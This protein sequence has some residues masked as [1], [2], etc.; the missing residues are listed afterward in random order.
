MDLQ[1][2]G[3]RYRDLDREAFLE[4]FP[5]PFL[6]RAGSTLKDESRQV[7]PLDRESLPVGRA[8]AARVSIP[9]PSVSKEHA[10]LRREDEAWLVTDE[11]STNGT[12]LDGQRL[13][14]GEPY[15]IE[16]GALVRFGVAAF[17]ITNPAELHRLL[18]SLGP[19]WGSDSEEGPN[20]SEDDETE[21]FFRDAETA[22]LVTRSD[23]SQT[24]L[25]QVLW[26]VE[27]RQSTGRVTVLGKDGDQGQIWFRAGRPCQAS[28]SEDELQG[29]P[30][31]Q[32]LVQVHQGS[33][34]LEMLESVPERR[35]EGTF[36]QLLFGQAWAQW[37][38]EQEAAEARLHAIVDNVFDA[39]VTVNGKG[40]IETVNPAAVALFGKPAA[41]LVGAMIETLL[42]RQDA[43]ERIRAGVGAVQ[44]LEGSR[45]G[46]PF[47]LELA[48]GFRRLADRDLFILTFRDLTQRKREEATLQV[49][50]KLE[51]VGRL[52]G[53]MTH[54]FNNLLTVIAGYAELLLEERVAPRTCGESILKA[55]KRATDLT[56]KILATTRLEPSAPVPLNLN[57]VL[58]ELDVLLRSILGE[59]CELELELSPELPNV[60]FDRGQLEQIVMNLAFNAR[61]ASVGPCQLLIRTELADPETVR[62]L[63]RDSGQ[64]IDAETLERVRE[65]FFTTKRAGSGLGLSVVEG[66]VR[67]AGGRLE[68]RSELGVGTEVELL[69]PLTPLEATAPL[70]ED[71]RRPGRV[72]VVEDEGELREL[73]RVILEGQGHQVTLARDGVE[74]LERFDGED[75]V[76][77][78]VVMP[79]LGGIGLVK[80]LLQLRPTQRVLYLSGYKDQALVGGF[81]LLP[82]PF[83]KTELQDAV[84]EAIAKS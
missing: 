29:V 39:I 8:F 65:P 74:A 41:D 2:F 27:A 51:A 19:A 35:I 50:Q 69:V 18:S 20:L 79:R 7:Y 59:D 44:E 33:L 47:P 76:V 58:G 4:R 57:Q 25:I 54:N 17:T 71:A 15:W 13:E 23:L 55:T 80:E 70:A 75:L 1:T 81:P 68:I 67:Q 30:A 45:D 38:R 42:D 83:S 31:L 61:D 60:L 34:I 26:N 52:S 3:Q 24:S 14:P 82:K 66:I 62:L 12:Y 32:R 9:H 53:D 21:R 72:L 84:W 64:G 46:E 77:T 6:L 11:G 73:I 10:T 5:A 16:E 22:H 40:L 37:R 56:R 36:S 28:A 43:L 63:V 78:D 48:V 49:A